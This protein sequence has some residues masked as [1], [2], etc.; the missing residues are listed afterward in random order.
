[1]FL[2]KDCCCFVF[3]GLLCIYA[4]S[5]GGCEH[6]H[7][8]VHKYMSLTARLQ[9]YL[10]SDSIT[11]WLI[12]QAGE[13]LL[14]WRL[15]IYEVYYRYHFF[16]I[17][18][19]VHCKLLQPVSLLLSFFSHV[20]LSPFF[21]SIYLSVTLSCSLLFYL[22]VFLISGFFFFSHLTVPLWLKDQIKLYQGE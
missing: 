1:M 13:M 18:S 20:F 15:K 3:L 16:A 5:T 19:G 9:V 4:N 6:T 7:W 11:F 14:N 2:K 17:A 8:N 21:L 10:I 22:C 12:V